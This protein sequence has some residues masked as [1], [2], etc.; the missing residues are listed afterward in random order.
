M[1]PSWFCDACSTENE[2]LKG[3]PPYVEIRVA[4]A[5]GENVYGCCDARCA[6][7]ILGKLRRKKR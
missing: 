4:K 1:A 5:A 2:G 3:T 6:M 7:T